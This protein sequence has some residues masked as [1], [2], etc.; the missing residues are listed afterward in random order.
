MCVLIF[1]DFYHYLLTNAICLLINCNLTPIPLCE[2]VIFDICA[3]KSL[4]VTVGIM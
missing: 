1:A 3:D 4:Q 2:L